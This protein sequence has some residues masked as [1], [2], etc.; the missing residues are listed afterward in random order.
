MLVVAVLTATV[1]V[2]GE[3]K[4]AI[5]GGVVSGTSQWNTSP[6]SSCI[7]QPDGTNRWVLDFTVDTSKNGFKFLKKDNG[8]PGTDWGWSSQMNNIQS[9][10][11][12]NGGGGGD[13]Q[14]KNFN[15]GDAVRMILT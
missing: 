1:C 6:P 5:T 11:N 2:Y 8:Q 9:G 15:N 4:F 7:F 13:M 10:T 3:N 12:M 14:L